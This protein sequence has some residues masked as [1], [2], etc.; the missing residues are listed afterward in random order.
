M[1]IL[2]I[3]MKNLA[4][5]DSVTEIDFTREPLNTAG[6]FAITGPTGA[7]KSTI[8]DALCLALYAKTPRY[9]LAE[10]SIDIADVKGSTIKQDDV[11]GILRDGTS[12]GFAGVD[13]IGVDGQAYS[14]GWSVRRARNK[15]DGNL[16]VAEITLKNITTNQ[17]IP[18]RKTELLEEIERLVGLNFEQ[19]TRSVLLAQGDFTAFLK[20]GKDEKSSLLEKL[21]GTHIYSEI[22]K[23]IFEN[24]REQQQELRD[25]NVQRGGIA[26]LAAEEI[27]ALKEEKT[28]LEALIKSGEIQA[29][30]LR[31]EQAWH[32]QRLNLQKQVGAAKAQHEAAI[33]DKSEALPRQELLQQIIRVQEIK[34]VISRLKDVRD[35]L[36]TNANQSEKLNVGLSDLQ[37]QQKRL[38]DLIIELT[39][40]LNNKT[41]K[42]EDTKPQLARARALDVQ[43][44]EKAQQLTQANDDVGAIREKQVK[45]ADQLKRAQEESES[46]KREIEKLHQWISENEARRAIAE[47]ESIIISKLENATEILENLQRYDSRILDSKNKINAYKQQKIHLESK[48]ISVRDSQ[49]YTQINHNA[50]NKALSGIDINRIEADESETEKLVRDII[51]A[52]AHWR[53]LYAAIGEQESL[54]K[55]FEYNKSELVKQSRNLAVMGKELEAKKIERDA[56]LKIFERAKL[57]AAESVERLR[58][59]LEQGE[60]CPVCGSKEH[61]YALHHPPLDDVLHGLKESYQQLISAYDSHLKLYSGLEESCTQLRKTITTQQEEISRKAAS[62]LGVQ[63]T[64]ADFRIYAS[65]KSIP[66]METQNWLQLQLKDHEATQKRLQEQMISYKKQKQE[67]ENLNDVLVG[68]DRELTTHENNIKDVDRLIVSLEEQV[69]AYTR[70]RQEAG[71]SLDKLRQRLSAYFASE[72]WFGNWQKDP[73]TFLNRI[74]KFALQWKENVLALEKNDNK[75]GVLT[76]TIGKVQEQVAES[77]EEL[78]LR[79]IKLNQVQALW[80]EVSNERVSIFNGMP[81]QEVEAGLSA[82]VASARLELEQKNNE[83][84]LL[85]NGIT[86]NSAQL[87]QLGKDKEGLLQ[88]EEGLTLQTVEWLNQYNVQHGKMLTEAELLPLLTFDQHWIETERNSLRVIDDAVMRAESIMLERNQALESHLQKRLSEKTSEELIELQNQVA[89]ILKQNIN[90]VSEIDFKIKEDEKHKD[91][92]GLLLQEI[93]Q[94][95]MVVDKWARLNDVVGSADGKKFRQI[96]QEYTLDVLISY[97]NVH[98]EALNKR[99]LLKRI[100]RSLGL[101]VIDQDMGDEERSVYSL[102]GGESFLVSLALALGLASLSSRRMKV[103]SLFI[104]EGFGSLDPTTLNIAMDALERL[105]NLGRKVGVI[106]HVQEMTERIPVQIRVSKQR[107]GKGKVEIIGV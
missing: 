97:A 2:S 42:E 99:Y 107:S 72:Q 54:R 25:L 84:E 13:F 64:W 37:Q 50:I 61:P 22:S 62:L 89:A 91:K 102:S 48:L 74:K 33:F 16:Q 69:Q 78:S 93:E 24:H 29:E 27:E 5:L 35:Q 45:Q 49:K 28:N 30:G 76:A 15:A 9:R 17:E 92:I 90:M 8:L 1:R 40:D 41:K 38:N 6:I 10:N 51:A 57:V 104:D 23:R 14:A 81:A 56:S 58:G 4:S 94:Q 103:E 82:A 98:L 43:L 80:N 101:S 20:A 36:A 47:Q 106:S 88:R 52:T 86:R 71:D 55:S 70:E 95:S 96:A 46:L 85:T 87:E 53:I 3:R 68:L 59:Q 77:A 18:G 11:R 75:L 63:K 79:E 66:V 31:K 65:A 105:H 32:E 39:N 60:P 34:P 26:T 19:F 7:G 83:A 67:L 21:T 12:E 100:P 73:E 44:A